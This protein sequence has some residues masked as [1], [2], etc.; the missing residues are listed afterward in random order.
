[1]SD[2]RHL[3][4]NVASY[5]PDKEIKVF[6]R[7]KIKRISAG[8]HF[9]E[10]V[11]EYLDRVADDEDLSRSAVLNRIIKKYAKERGDSIK[12]SQYQPT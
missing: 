1:M 4:N 12:S 10:G 8:V 6:M 9:E 11:L 2:V 5:L 7:K 3:S